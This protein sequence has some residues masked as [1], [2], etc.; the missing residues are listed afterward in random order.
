MEQPTPP[1]PTTR[2]PYKE[3]RQPTPEQ[4][5]QVEEVRWRCRVLYH[6]ALEQ[7]RTGWGRGQGQSATRFPQEAE[8]TALRAAFPADAALHAQVLQEVLA[9]LETTY[10]AVFRRLAHGEKPGVPRFQGRHRSPSFPSKEYGTGAHLDN[11]TLVRATRGRI[12]ARWRR[13]LGGTPKTVT[14]SKEADGWYVAF[15][16]GEVPVQPLPQTGKET[17][18]AVGLKVFLVTADGETVEH[19]RHYRNA[20]KAVATAQQRVSRRTKGSRRRNTA[21]RVRA[22]KHQKVRG[23]RQDFHHQTARWLV[24]QYDTI[25]LE[26][27]RVAHLVRNHRLAK[28]ISAAGWAAVRTALAYKAVG[29]GKP[30]VVVVDAASTTQACSGGGTRVAKSLRLRTPLCPSCGLVLDRDENAAS[31]IPWRGQRR[32]GLAGLPA[33]MHRAPAG[34]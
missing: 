10:Q 4:E 20:E 32:R 28:S 15:S 5:R 16:C 19:P 14:V 25:S 11:G 33:G 26:D 24:R 27:L 31:T 18:I 6:T 23:Q 9:R 34:L 7:R 30:V 29:A 1:M 12:A 22:K 21:R 13:P 17:G 8:L 2:R 3:Q